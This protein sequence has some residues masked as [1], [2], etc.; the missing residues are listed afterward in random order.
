[1]L[2]QLSYTP[3]GTVEFRLSP[4]P[5]A[6]PEKTPALRRKLVFALP[7]PLGPDRHGF[8]AGDSG[9]P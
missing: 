2:Y 8:V 4:L 1:M 7:G 9:D 6:R 5:A 3:R